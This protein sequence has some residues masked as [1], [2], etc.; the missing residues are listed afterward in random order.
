[1][2]FIYTERRERN[3]VRQPILMFM[4]E[5]EEAIRRG[6]QTAIP[7]TLRKN[8]FELNYGSSYKFEHF[9]V[10]F[11]FFFSWQDSYEKQDLTRSKTN[12]VIIAD[13]V[14]VLGVEHWKAAFEWLG[15][16]ILVSLS[17]FATPSQGIHFSRIYLS[18]LQ[19]THIRCLSSS[20]TETYYQLRVEIF[21]TMRLFARRNHFTGIF[22]VKA[23]YLQMIIMVARYNRRCITFFFFLHALGDMHFPFSFPAYKLSIFLLLL[24]RS[25]SCIPRFYKLVQNL[26]APSLE[27]NEKNDL[28]SRS[29]YQ[30]L[31]VPILLRR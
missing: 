15:C 4:T 7:A 8:T 12:I 9:S 23:I 19:E 17:N 3:Q 22:Y 2:N 14:R 21:R 25:Y 28:F 24:V 27:W 30:R 1:M 11:F 16:H 6:G 18:V 31:Q 5:K 13:G 26:H 20:A 29:V 10:N